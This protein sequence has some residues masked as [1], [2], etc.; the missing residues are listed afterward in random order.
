MSLVAEDT[1]SRKRQLYAA[2]ARCQAAPVPD[3]W[4]RAQ[5]LREMCRTVSKPSRLYARHVAH[6]TA[7]ADD[8]DD[9]WE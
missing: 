3:A 1:A 2:V 7:V 5:M 4:L 9:K 8:Q 6:M